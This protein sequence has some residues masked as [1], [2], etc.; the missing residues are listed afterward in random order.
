[1]SYSKDQLIRVMDDAYHDKAKRGVLTATVTTNFSNDAS[2]LGVEKLYTSLSNTV[3][4]NH[5]LAVQ[6][7]VELMG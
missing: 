1:M 5:A 3:D 4:G 6:A 2:S 7:L